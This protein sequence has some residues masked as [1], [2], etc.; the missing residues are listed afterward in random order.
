MNMNPSKNIFENICRITDTHHLFVDYKAAFNSSI[1]DPVFAA[2]S[3]HG[4]PAKLI[5]LCRMT[6]S[7]SCS[8]IK[9]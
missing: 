1:R 2:K 7:N 6:L 8:F 5:K 3:E 9:V 4:I